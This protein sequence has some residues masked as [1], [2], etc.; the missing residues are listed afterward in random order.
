MGR[1][2]TKRKR[3]GE[4]EKKTIA[5]LRKRVASFAITAADV[6]AR[7]TKLNTRLVK[8]LQSIQP[9]VVSKGTH[10]VRFAGEKFIPDAVLE[11]RARTGRALFAPV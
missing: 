2:P 9:A 8:Y 1:T 11:G 5:A 10:I 6:T 7:E 3:L 4:I